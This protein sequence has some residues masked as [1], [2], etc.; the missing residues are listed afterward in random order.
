MIDID[1]MDKNIDMFL[2]SDRAELAQEFGGQTADQIKQNIQ[3]SMKTFPQNHMKGVENGTDGSG[4]TKGQKNWLNA[5][6]GAVNQDHIARNP[7]LT[8]LGVK[9]AQNIASYRSFRL[10]RIGTMEQVGEGAYINDMK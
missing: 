7:V 9:K 3:T 10:D 2:R 1:S 8:G 5:V 4:I 6:F